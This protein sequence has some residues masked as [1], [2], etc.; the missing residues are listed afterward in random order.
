MM[1]SNFKSKVYCSDLQ[2]IYVE[3]VIDVLEFTLCFVDKIY[4]LH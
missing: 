3:V 2:S 4:S 1:N